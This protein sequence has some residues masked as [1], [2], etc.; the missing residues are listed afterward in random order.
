MTGESSGLHFISGK[1]CAA[2]RAQV[3][4][5][6]HLHP[7]AVRHQV[8]CSL[9]LSDPC[10][11]RLGNGPCLGSRF[12]PQHWEMLGCQPLQSGNCNSL[13]GCIGL[14]RP[15]SRLGLAAVGGAPRV[16][17]WETAQGG[18]VR[19]DVRSTLHVS[20]MTQRQSGNGWGP[21]ASRGTVGILLLILNVCRGTVE[22]P[23]SVGE[24]LGWP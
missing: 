18:R 14:W 9:G 17:V 10:A 16:R 5:S 21:N 2:S 7:P 15:A 11:R 22:Y 1:L 12:E 23:T 20:W 24:R 6:L 13:G 19:F 3:G 4:L 8:L